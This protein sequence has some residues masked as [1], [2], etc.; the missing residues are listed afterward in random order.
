MDDG[1]V[2]AV[3]GRCDSP[4]RCATMEMRI[5]KKVNLQLVQVYILSS[6]RRDTQFIPVLL[7]QLG[8]Q[9]ARFYQST[10][11]DPP[12]KYNQVNSTTRIASITADKL[13][14]SRQKRI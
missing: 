13:E 8:H 7:P 14:E 11:N 6:F 3:D 4:G 12:L 5:N 10:K 2:V 9:T 1:L